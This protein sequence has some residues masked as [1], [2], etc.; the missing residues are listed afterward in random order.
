MGQKSEAVNVGCKVLPICDVATLGSMT[1]G[2]VGKG[3]EKGVQKRRKA[4]S[5]MKELVRWAAAAKSA[6]GGIKA[7]KYDEP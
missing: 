1:S 5:R 4:V 3:V 7:W 2:D 6:K